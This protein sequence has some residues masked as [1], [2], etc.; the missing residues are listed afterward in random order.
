MSLETKFTVNVYYSSYVT[1]C[2]IHNI[3]VQ[4][5]LDF[6]KK[7]ELNPIEKGSMDTFFINNEPEDYDVAEVHSSEFEDVDSEQ[8]EQFMQAVKEVL[9]KK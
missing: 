3:T 7:Q 8:A 4:D 9:N 2:A 1:E 5:Y 6:C